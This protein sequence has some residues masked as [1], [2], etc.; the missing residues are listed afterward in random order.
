VTN[1][2]YRLIVGITIL[3]GLYL[4]SAYVIYGLIGVLLLEG[5]TNTLISNT[6]MQW[7]T[8]KSC[9]PYEGCLGFAFSQRLNIDAERSWRITVAAVLTVSYVFFFKVLWFLPWFMGF[10]ISGAGI[11]GVCPMLLLLRKVGF[12]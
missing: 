9:D 8:G 11:S 12:R 3:V 2:T 10:A 1:K 5:S 6:L 4:E 7:R